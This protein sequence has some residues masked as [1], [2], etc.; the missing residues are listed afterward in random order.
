MKK[1][2]FLTALFL[3]GLYLI[4][5]SQSV[6][7]VLNKDNQ[8]IKMISK[9]ITENGWVYLN[10]NLKLSPNELIKTHK[11]AFGYLDNDKVVLNKTH[12]DSISEV[13]YYKRF[14]NNIEV[15]NSE[16]VIHTKKGQSTLCYG[17]VFGTF[18]SLS[19]F[20]TEEMAFGIAKQFIYPKG[21]FPT[22]IKI[23][24]VLKEYRPKGKLIY[25]R[26]QSN[27]KN[28]SAE[29][30]LS[31]KYSVVSVDPFDIKTIYID[32][33]SGTILNVKSQ[34][35]KAVGT[36]NTWYNGSKS[37]TTYFIQGFPRGK[38]RLQ[39]RSRGY[40]HPKDGCT[41]GYYLDAYGNYLYA[42]WDIRNFYE[43]TSSNN[44]GPDLAS[45]SLWAIERAYDYFK[46]VFY[47]NGTDG[48]NREVRIYPAGYLLGSEFVGSMYVSSDD[49]NEATEQTVEYDGIYVLNPFTQGDYT[50]TL[51]VLGH[52]FTHGINHYFN[53]VGNSNI[54][55]S[56]AIQESFCD[57][58]GEMIQAYTLGITP[59]WKGAY[60]ASTYSY[61]D[62]ASPNSPENPAFKAAAF[63]NDPYWGG[64]QYAK[65]GVQN[66]WFYL[67]SNSIGY[68]NA[69]KIAYRNMTNYLITTSNYLDAR[70]GSINASSDFFGE[71][72]YETQQVMN[73]WATVGVG[74]A[75]TPCL[76]VNIV[77][78]ES[79]MCGESGYYSA[80]V[81]GGSGF[82]S[83]SWYV[84]YTLYSNESS[85]SLG[86]YPQYGDEY[87]N[88]SLTVTDAS[89]SDSD[90][91]SI[92]IFNCG[93]GNKSSANDS[94]DILIYPNPAT[95]STK[96]TIDQSFIEDSKSLSVQII[97]QN[98]KLVFVKKFYEK[99]ITINTSAFQKGIYNVLLKTEKKNGNA[100]LIIK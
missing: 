12:K 89:L 42:D 59:D 67:L 76:Q 54:I 68:M 92:F 13:F 1:L 55:E 87:H 60:E 50:V 26:I 7:Y 63:V 79:L 94:P 99:E 39:D 38:F 65:A 58:F 97:D 72:S 57:I 2:L 90:D 18:N 77:G 40:I 85:I 11:K 51:D 45:T 48:N 95:S 19:P 53:D 29:Y 27:D 21:N 78:P 35:N 46:N 56:Q 41:G 23:D 96:I 52:E 16:F 43:K 9:R 28:N 100:K 47:R 88:I 62:L 71:C 64:N 36:V 31:Y 82:Y 66:R 84:D 25:T 73:A 5:Y 3:L 44:W 17:E 75:A 30:I 81:Y 22:K 8:Q 14:H 49:W 98:G 91:K 80:N 15:E 86:F 10:D 70:E 37:I 33:L 32:G 83:Y 6:P 69:A 24:S 93:E 4:T 34:I 61:K 74:A 20:L